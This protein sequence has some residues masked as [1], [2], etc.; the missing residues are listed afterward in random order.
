MKEKAW[1]REVLDD[2][3]KAS[4]PKLVF[5]KELPKKEGFYW[6][7]NFGEHTPVVLEVRKDYTDG[8]RLYAQNEEFCFK[9]ERVN[10][11]KNIEQCKKYEIEPIDGYY[12]GEQLW[13]YIPSPWLPDMKKQVEPDCY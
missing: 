7:T 1:L 8:G 12:H 11:K 5:T 10:R 6:Y 13:C 4:E 2:A 9:V 3:K